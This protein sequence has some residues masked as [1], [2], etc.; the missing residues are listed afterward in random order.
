MA[1]RKFPKA[2]IIRTFELKTDLIDPPKVKI[3]LTPAS[4]REKQR[5]LFLMAGQVEDR[6]DAEFIKSLPPGELDKFINA[7]GESAIPIVLKHIVGWDLTVEGKAIP[8]TDEEKA[9]TWFED[10]LWEFVEPEKPEVGQ[11]DPG[12]DDEDVD[13]QGQ[14]KKR[15][16]TWLWTA[17][18]QIIGERGNFS[19]N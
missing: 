3:E 13:E 4:N 2:T 17:I 12:D 18:M 14:P 15:A 7:L 19:K 16:D 6:A 11:L 5:Y 10:L 9:R 1:E 8:C